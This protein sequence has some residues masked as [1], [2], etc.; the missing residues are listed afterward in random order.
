MGLFSRL[1]SWSANEPLGTSLFTRWKGQLVGTDAYGN[2]YF[3]ERK[4]SGDTARGRPTRRWVLYKGEV[5]GSKVPPEW[6][7]W[8]HGTHLEAPN[9]D[10]KRHAWESPHIA[11]LTGTPDAWRPPGSLSQGGRRPRGTGDYEAWRPAGDEP[12]RPS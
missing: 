1:F 3:Q 2:R 6:H 10:R 8:L 11:N 9:P 4:P 5:D 7:G 12:R